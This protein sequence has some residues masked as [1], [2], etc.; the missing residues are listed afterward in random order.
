MFRE[1][2]RSYW[3][4]RRRYAIKKLPGVQ[5]IIDSSVV[6]ENWWFD[7]YHNVDT[8]PQIS[9]QRERGWTKDTTNFH[10]VPIRPKSIRRALRN[11][12]VKDCRDYTFI[13]FGSGKGRA[14]LMAAKHGFRKLRAI[15]LRK[16]LHEQA[17]SNF[18]RCRNLDSCNME[19]ININAAE[20][21]FP[22]QKL[23]LFFFNPFG[24]QVMEAV[25]ENL[26]ASLDCHFRD[27]W[28]I[29]QDSTCSYLADKTLQLR[30]ESAQNQHRIYRS[31]P[32][33]R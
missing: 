33:E 28:V 25:L 27:V 9:E 1:I 12:P 18:C 5:R 19:S 29:L 15:E 17:C 10:Y 6:L 31:V 26:G 4:P 32:R 24:R 22:N 20:Y 14:V 2:V 16:E 8:A 3:E 13:D 23:V 30:F 21:E 11:L 7:S